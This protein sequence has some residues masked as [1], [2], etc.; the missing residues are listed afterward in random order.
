MNI[1]KQ[2]RTI[3]RIKKQVSDRALKYYKKYKEERDTDAL[4]DYLDESQVICHLSL[5][6]N[7]LLQHKKA[8][9][10]NIIAI[11]IN[12]FSLGLAILLIFNA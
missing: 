10:I 5:E 8:I 11:F 6:E 9:T 3:K 2:I 12:I 1:D 4:I 7:L